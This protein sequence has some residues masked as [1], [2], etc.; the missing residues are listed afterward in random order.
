M[1]DETKNER[2]LEKEERRKYAP[3]KF[4]GKSYSFDINNEKGILDNLRTWA[5]DYFTSNVVVKND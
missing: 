1:E 3:Y 2:Q 5:V 4:S